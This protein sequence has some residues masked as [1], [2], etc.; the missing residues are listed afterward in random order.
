MNAWMQSAAYHDLLGFINGISTAIQG[1]RISDDIYISPV[2]ANLLGIFEKLNG[3]IDETPPIDQPQR[4]GNKAY[5]TWS[6]KVNHVSLFKKII[7]GII[8]VA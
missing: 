6:R 8:I 2:M 4:F 1:K 7:K 3:L 5:R